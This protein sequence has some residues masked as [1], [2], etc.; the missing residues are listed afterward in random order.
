MKQNQLSEIQKDFIDNLTHEFKTP[1]SSLKLSAEVLS[2]KDIIKEP[3][4]IDKYA[5]IISVY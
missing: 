1:I 2:D 4:R 3:S 5:N